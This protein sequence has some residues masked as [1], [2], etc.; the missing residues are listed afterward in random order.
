MS[1]D[2]LTTIKFPIWMKLWDIPFDFFSVKGIGYIAN[3]VGK[4]FCLD[5][6]H[7]KVGESTLRR[8]VLRWKILMAFLT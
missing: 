3:A 4:P 6:E 1:I 5:N 8:Y 7:M 2:R